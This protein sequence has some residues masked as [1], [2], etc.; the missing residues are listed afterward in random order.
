MVIPTVAQNKPKSIKALQDSNNP[1]DE[2]ADDLL[3]VPSSLAGLPSIAVPIGGRG[4]FPISLQV[5]GPRFSDAL[6]L[7][8]AQKLMEMKFC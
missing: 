2:W 3:T 6:V 4:R 5:I 7:E 1:I 8:V